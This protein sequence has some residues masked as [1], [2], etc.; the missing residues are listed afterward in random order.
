[1]GT[2]ED[3]LR[4]E[5]EEQEKKHKKEKKKRVMETAVFMRRSKSLLCVSK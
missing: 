2:E 3:E 1:M 5:L 4:K